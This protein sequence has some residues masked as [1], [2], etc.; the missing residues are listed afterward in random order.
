VL[1]A[2]AVGLAIGLCEPA[3]EPDRLGETVP[4]GEVVELREGE[5]LELVLTDPTIETDAD[6]EGEG[7][8]VAQADQVPSFE[9]GLPVELATS[10]VEGDWLEQDDCDDVGHCDWDPEGEPLSLALGE[11][12]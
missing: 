3:S 10:E 7:V 12:V 11:A 1:L 5:P 9:V 8:T 2:T 6:E 4:V